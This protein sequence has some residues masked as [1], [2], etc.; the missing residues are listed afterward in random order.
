MRFTMSALFLLLA[1]C[2]PAERPAD[3][4]C[5]RS[6]DMFCDYYTRCD[7]MAAE[8]LAECK[9]NFLEACNAVYEPHYV[10]LA[11]Q[12]L[13]TLSTEGLRECAAH[14]ETV[15]CDQQI[16]DL[17]GGCASVWQGQAPAGAPCG[18]GIESFVCDAASTCV[19]GLDLCGTCE[20]TVPVGAPCDEARCEATA[21]CI[22]GTCVARALP[23]EACGDAR[24]CV[25][26]ASCIDEVCVAPTIAAVDEACGQGVR[27]P[28]K[29]ACVGGVCVEAAL[30]GEACG[31]EITCASGWCEDGTCAPL[32]DGGEACEGAIECRS[33]SCDEVCAELPGV[34]FE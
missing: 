15:T 14:L 1:A 18:L 34:C 29:S 11:E 4:Y 23:G 12:G 19:I 26:G 8:S 7:R 2:A 13:L 25:M 5:E 33:L 10:A 22:E 28:Y 6:V 3:E 17:D 24:A 31:A 16:F 20:A 21:S 9:T 27:C 30:Q 32:K